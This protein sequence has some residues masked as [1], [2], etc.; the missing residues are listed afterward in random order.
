[1]PC[2]LVAAQFHNK[3]ITHCFTYIGGL[4]G[5]FDFGGPDG[6]PL[7]GFEEGFDGGPD[8][9]PLGGF[10]EGFDGG[11]L[12]GP[13]GGADGG[14]LGGPDGGALLISSSAAAVFFAGLGKG[15][16]VAAVFGLGCSSAAGARFFENDRMSALGATSW[17]LGGV[18]ATGFGAKGADSMSEDF[19]H[20]GVL[21]ASSWGASAASP[22]AIAVEPP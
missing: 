8:G 11:P 12:G 1:M 9:G 18:S 19:S 10:E 15:G 22:T 6:G 14:P 20:G 5:F 2:S 13:L 17:S 3:S 16:G 21:A 4:D 7:G